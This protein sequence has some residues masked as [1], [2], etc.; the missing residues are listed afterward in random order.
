MNIIRFYISF[1]FCFILF[2]CTSDDELSKEEGESDVVA[3]SIGELTFDEMLTID[4]GKYASFCNDEIFKEIAVQYKK[5]KDEVYSSDEVNYEYTL[6]VLDSIRMKIKNYADE[7]HCVNLITYIDKYANTELNLSRCY[8]GEETE[9][10]WKRAWE[11]YN[12]V[13]EKSVYKQV[14]D[15]SAV[16]DD[17]GKYLRLESYAGDI[18]F[19]D[20]LRYNRTWDQIKMMGGLKLYFNTIG[21]GVTTDSEVHFVNRSLYDSFYRYYLSN[22]WREIGGSKNN[23]NICHNCKCDPCICYTP[24]LQCGYLKIECICCKICG[25]YPCQCVNNI[26]PTHPGGMK[27]SS[28]YSDWKLYEWDKRMKTKFESFLLDSEPIGG[29]VARANGNIEKLWEVHQRVEEAYTIPVQLDDFGFLHLYRSEVSEIGYNRPTLLDIAC[30]VDAVK[31]RKELRTAVGIP[32]EYPALYTMFFKTPSNIY[33]LASWGNLGDL[34]GVLSHGDNI[35]N[36]IKAVGDYISEIE[37]PKPF[38]HNNRKYTYVYD[39]NGEELYKIAAALSQL[40]SDIQVLKYAQRS[41]V[42]SFWEAWAKDGID[43]EEDVIK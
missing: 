19:R 3:Q 4:N 36:C 8:F 39:Y 11:Y 20:V 33:V 34:D 30:F 17:L 2:A 40:G 24:C 22:R 43:R 25:V 6:K 21:M 7:C 27:G 14:N 15:Q 12:N 28:V 31:R 10:C 35:D 5:N 26:L 1:L 13:Y 41:G 37:L 42:E 16:I 38:I 23:P 32:P 29:F 18:V 9:A